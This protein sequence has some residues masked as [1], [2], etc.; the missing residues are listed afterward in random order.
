MLQLAADA[1]IAGGEALHDGGHLARGGFAEAEAGL[2]GGH[3]LGGG[4]VNLFVEHGPAEAGG[5]EGGVDVVESEAVDGHVGGGVVAEDDHEG[6]GVA[7]GEGDG[8]SEFAEDAGALDLI[9]FGEDEALGEGGA[10]SADLLG[11]VEQDAHLDDRGGLDGQVGRERGG[12]AGLEIL[13]EEGDMAV[14]GGGDGGNLLVECAV[15]VQGGRLGGGGDERDAE[16]GEQRRGAAGSGASHADR[17]ARQRAGGAY[18][19]RSKVSEAE[20][21]Q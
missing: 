7:E 5:A 4:D 3:G 16:A 6:E 21:M 20:L 1:E 8:R 10:A 17:V 9:G 14:V 19:A 11:G 15:F 18:S 12:E 13:G 2:V